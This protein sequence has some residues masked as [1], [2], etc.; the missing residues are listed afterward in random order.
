MYIFPCLHKIINEG[1]T[2]WN[3]G[4]ISLLSSLRP[5]PPLSPPARLH[6]TAREHSLLQAN[7]ESIGWRQRVEHSLGMA[8]PW[9]RPP[10]DILQTFLCYIWLL[11]AK[12]SPAQRCCHRCDKLHVGTSCHP[13]A[14]VSRHAGV[15]AR[16]EF[17]RQCYPAVAPRVLCGLQFLRGSGTLKGLSEPTTRKSDLAVWWRQEGV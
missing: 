2:R 12:N 4:M 7:M 1:E 3:S 8:S 6:P 13:S 10:Q 14:D 15:E 5:P 9:L 16:M 11:S 17:A